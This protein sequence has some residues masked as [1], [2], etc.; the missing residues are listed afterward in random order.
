[1][2][3]KLII[4]GLKKAYKGEKQKKEGK[5]A[6]SGQRRKSKTEAAE[7]CTESVLPLRSAVLN[8]VPPTSTL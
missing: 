5:T 3:S 7:I 1:M 6:W 8:F 2:L 4:K